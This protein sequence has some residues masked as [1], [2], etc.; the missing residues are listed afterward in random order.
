VVERF[1]M[2]EHLRHGDLEIER[3][4]HGHG[5]GE[6]TKGHFSY[7][8][9]QICTDDCAWIRKIPGPW[10]GNDAVLVDLLT[11]HV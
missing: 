2:S 3:P 9:A 10:Y 4:G 8:E 1:E 6:D 11:V 5:P 7:L